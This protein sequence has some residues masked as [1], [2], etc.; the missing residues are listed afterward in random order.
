M[1]KTN[2]IKRGKGINST[3]DLKYYKE[4]DAAYY[5]KCA[6]GFFSR[7][8][9][10]IV[11]NPINSQYVIY[12][13]VCHLRNAEYHLNNSLLC[14]NIGL[15]SIIHTFCLI[16]EYWKLRS[17]SYKTGFQIP[18][19]VCGPGLRILHYG[20]IVINENTRIGN[21]LTIYPGV[22]IGHKYRGGGAPIIGDNCFIGAGAKI[23]GNIHIGNNVTIAPNAVV[24]KDIPDN[25]VVG[26]VPGKII[27]VK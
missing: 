3:K 20:W 19:N 17:Y 7:L 4:C 15:C 10:A 18:P 12:R 24:T 9:N 13:Y 22:E 25:C 21:N 1:L 2:K 6:S 23:F 11:T 27:K 14:N 16:Y 26:G 5:G 8:A